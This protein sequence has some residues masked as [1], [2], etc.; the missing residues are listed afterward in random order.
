MIKHLLA[1]ALALVGLAVPLEALAAPVAITWYDFDNKVSRCDYYCPSSPGVC[2]PTCTPER[3]ELPDGDLIDVSIEHN[4]V[5]PDSIE[6]RLISD[7][8]TWRQITINDGS[9]AWT[10][11]TYEEWFARHSYCN[12]PDPATPGCDTIG[13]WSD[14]T[15]A[16]GEIVFTKAGSFWW[17]HE[18]VYVLR[19]LAGRLSPGDR[20]TFH[21]VD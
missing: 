7:V 1:P 6:F 17:E 15:L 19:N 12:W 5:A 4:A 3:V 8:T 21:W 10:V 9:L 14:P 20:V 13:H 18:D 16:H 11:W 2:Y